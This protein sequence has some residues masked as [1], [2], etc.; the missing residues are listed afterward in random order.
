MHLRCLSCAFVWVSALLLLTPVCARA[1]ETWVYS[2][3]VR[4]RVLSVDEL[5]ELARTKGSVERVSTL[6][7]GEMERTVLRFGTAGIGAPGFT[8][9]VRALSD[10]GAPQGVGEDGRVKKVIKDGA[11]TVYTWAPSSGEEGALFEAE[12]YADNNLVYTETRK[13]F[14]SGAQMLPEW[15]RVDYASGG[16]LF[17]YYVY[18][19]KREGDFLPLQEYGKGSTALQPPTNNTKE[20]GKAL[21]E[22]SLHFTAPQVGFD[23]GFDSGWWPGGNEEPGGFP[24]QVRIAMQGAY[25]YDADVQGV[26]GLEQCVLRPGAAQGEWGFAFGAQMIFKASIDIGVIPP[27]VLNIPFVP[28]FDILADDRDAFYNWLLD[29]TS[30]LSDSTPRTTFFTYDL[31][32]W[33]K[34][35]VNIPNWIPFNAGAAADLSIDARGTLTCDSI[36]L[37]DGTTFTEEGQGQTVAV[38]SGVYTAWANYN[39]Q[40]TLAITIHAYPVLFVSFL[41]QTWDLPLLDIPWTPISGPID[42]NFSTDNV[43]YTGADPCVT[44]GAAEGEGAME[45]EGAIEGSSEGTVE[46]VSEGSAEGMTEGVFEGEGG[47][48]EGEGTVEGEGTSEGQVEGELPC[49][50]L[51]SAPGAVPILNLQQ[52]QSQIFV[53]NAGRVTHVEVQLFLEH[54]AVGELVGTLQSPSGKFAFLFAQVGGSGANFEGT[55]FTDDAPTSIQEGSAP[56]A[57][58]FRPR[59]SFSRFVGENAQGLWTLRIS[60]LGPQNTGQLLAW[61]LKLNECTEGEGTTEGTSEGLGEGMPEGVVEGTVE[62]NLEG[63]QEGGTEGTLEGVSEGEAETPNEGEGCTDAPHSA[64]WCIGCC[65]EQDHII[66]L[67]ELLRVIQLYNSGSFG[68]GIGTEDGYSPGSP[69]HS[70]RPHSADY[71]PQDWRFSLPE[72]LRVIQFFNAG[73]YHACPGAGTEDGFCVGRP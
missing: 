3:F 6:G 37:S 58:A 39:E 53:P 46:G 40:A 4:N 16:T 61:T 2:A 44:E 63:M 60:D 70:C 22:D 69:D 57:G 35:L 34:D 13:E 59:D 9:L 73:G 1:E 51:A 25:A 20:L 48:F 64:D 67:S 7:G 56:F 27:L 15:I 33:I 14:L 45:G 10:K 38:E 65:G 31:T 72:L 23:V 36:S 18:G 62:G 55:I 47:F 29:S 43:E 26:F 66:S 42:L 49:T 68:C 71:N 52:A 24:L 32:G 21:L 8:S 5:K 19:I 41:G 11:M 28:N 17:Q 54:P 50:T 30:N 12:V